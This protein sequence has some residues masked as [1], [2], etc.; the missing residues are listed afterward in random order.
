M[1]VLYRSSADGNG[2]ASCAPIPS[3]AKSKA[4]TTL[5]RRFII[6]P[7]KFLKMFHSMRYGMNNFTGLESIGVI[8]VVFLPF[9]AL[10]HA[11]KASD[12]RRAS[13]VNAPID[14]THF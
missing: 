11:A 10:G 3:G 9:H 8:S 6:C 7:R 5:A 4:K 13:E 1:S 14:N 12:F 2:F